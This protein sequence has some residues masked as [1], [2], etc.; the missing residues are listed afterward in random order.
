MVEVEGGCLLALLLQAVIC[1]QFPYL[2]TQVPRLK[3]GANNNNPEVFT[4]SEI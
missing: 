4:I 2:C 3:Y 1:S